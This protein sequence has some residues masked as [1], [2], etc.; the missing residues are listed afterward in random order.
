MML[1]AVKT[2]PL[3][4]MSTEKLF[5]SASLVKLD[6]VE[7]VSWIRNC[8]SH[9]NV[10]I[11]SDVRKA[12]NDSQLSVLKTNN[13]ALCEHLSLNTRVGLENQLN[14]FLMNA[15]LQIIKTL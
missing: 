13:Q 2:I 7:A 10:E 4:S 6:R 11:V 9:S 12:S 15:L 1:K 5:M 8:D 14:A 3:K